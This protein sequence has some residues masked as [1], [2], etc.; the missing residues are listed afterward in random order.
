V[1]GRDVVLTREQVRSFVPQSRR[2]AE[3]DEH[4]VWL[5]SSN[6]ELIPVQE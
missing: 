4:D 2:P 1:S 6:E 5:L 3:L